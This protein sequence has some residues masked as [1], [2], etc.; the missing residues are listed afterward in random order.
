MVEKRPFRIVIPLLIAVVTLTAVLAALF[1]NQAN[2]PLTSQMTA[3]KSPVDLLAQTDQEALYARG[4][5]YRSV[6]TAVP[7]YYQD[8]TGQWQ[9][10]NPA[11]AAS[12]VDF[13]VVANSLTS[14]S[15]RN[16]AW[17]AAGTGGA[18]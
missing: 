2:R 5:G 4:D 13:S 18:E 17:I 16:R 12:A 11:F 9:P 10:I 14:R 8:A 7:G 3:V 15:G 6:L 1:S